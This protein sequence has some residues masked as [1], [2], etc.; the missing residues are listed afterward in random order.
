MQ[1]KIYDLTIALEFFLR[2]KGVDNKHTHAI[3]EHYLT[4]EMTGKT[5]HGIK[6]LIWDSQYF[7]PNSENGFKIIKDNQNSVLIDCNKSIGSSVFANIIDTI[8]IPQTLNNSVFITSCINFQRFGSPY[9][10]IKKLVEKDIICLFINNTD[11]FVSTENG[12]DCTLGTNPIAIGIPYSKF[13]I[14]IDMATSKVSANKMFEAKSNNSKIPSNTYLDGNFQFTDKV[15]KAKYIIP[16]GD[17]KGF[18]LSFIIQLLT[19]CFLG[20]DQMSDTKNIYDVGA[21][22]ITFKKDLFSESQKLDRNLS[23]FVKKFNRIAGQKSFENHQKALKLDYI[24]I[25][26]NIYDQLL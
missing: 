7:E 24:Q 20:L 8:V 22:I 10:F 19:T 15:E 23:Q 5:T 11:P 13:P 2:R 26:K 16:F 1:I 12:I 25:P 17:Y 21:M 6:K 14:I 18:N 4:A 3:I 9:S